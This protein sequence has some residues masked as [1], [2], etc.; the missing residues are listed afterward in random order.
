MVLNNDSFILKGRN[1]KFVLLSFKCKN[2]ANTIFQY[3]FNMLSNF[4]EKSNVLIF[5]K[6]K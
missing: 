5:R 4:N 1:A 6:T 3:I 2:R